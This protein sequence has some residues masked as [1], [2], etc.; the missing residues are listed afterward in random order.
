MPIQH[1][2]IGERINVLCIDKLE[3]KIGGECRAARQC[4][5]AAAKRDTAA[6]GCPDST[7][8]EI[9]LGR[10]GSN[11]GMGE[12]KSPALPLGYAPSDGGGT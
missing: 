6:A 5:N 8:G 9:W 4:A 1:I 11:L 3:W 10:Q 12:S 7:K 2:G